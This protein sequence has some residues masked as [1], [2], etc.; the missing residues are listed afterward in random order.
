M[1]RSRPQYLILAESE[2]LK[3]SAYWFISSQKCYFFV[4]VHQGQRGWNGGQLRGGRGQSDLQGQGHC[5][6]KALLNKL[7][8]ERSLVLQSR[9]HLGPD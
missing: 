3:V 2:G 9:R 7:L 4:P 5:H 6:R 1:F 8:H